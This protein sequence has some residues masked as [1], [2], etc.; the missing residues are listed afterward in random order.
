MAMRRTIP[1]LIVAL[2]L[3]VG[4]SADAFARAGGGGSFGSRG[5][6]TF[7][8]PSSAITAP[9][10]A[11]PFQRSMTS[12][13][14]GIF[15]PNGTGPGAR[16]GIFGVFGGGLLGGLLG[17]GLIGM[18]FGHGFGGGLGGGMSFI[19]LLLQLAL[20]YFVF[21]FVMNFLRNRS[22]AQGSAF[23]GAPPSGASP[24]GGANPQGGFGGGFGGFGAAPQ[25]SKLDIGP[26][27]FSAFEQRLG[28]IQQAYSDEDLNRLRSMVT[29]EMA[30]YFAEE[31]ADT[32]KKGLVNKLSNVQFLQ[33]DLA[34]A[35]REAGGENA[36]VAIPFTLNDAK[37]DRATG[38][39]V[40]GDHSTPQQATE[41]W[42]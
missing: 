23:T 11:S 38:R 25:Q 14:Q 5:G 28:A 15:R 12:P 16:G 39:V 35:W 36:S 8:R 37:H 21:K 6:M 31:I 41:N 4:F 24:Y 29:P 19:G 26:A 10:G 33:G 34:E 3:A 30:S 1:I 40:S 18:L 13:N 42:T 7:S 2:T 27:D 32:A 17:A 9:Y 22:P 20:L